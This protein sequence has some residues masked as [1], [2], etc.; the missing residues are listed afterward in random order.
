MNILL[1][2]IFIIKKSLVFSIAMVK[3]DQ[4]KWKLKMENNVDLVKNPSLKLS[5]FELLNLKEKE[6]IAEDLIYLKYNAGET[7]RKQGAFLSHVIIIVE[8]LAK[9]VLENKRDNIIVRML[10]SGSI[11]GGP[12]MFY[13]QKHHYSVIPLVSTTVVFIEKTRFRKIFNENHA[14]RDSFIS[15]MSRTMLVSFDR[16]LNLSQ[17]HIANRIAYSLFYLCDEVFG[18][19]QIAG[20]ITKLEIAELSATSVESV[21]R[22]IRK[23]EQAGYIKKEKAIIRILDKAGLK[24]YR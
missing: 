6:F 16:M 17:K 13:D 1:I 4:E 22:T 7:I 23:F 14:F 9:L 10:K 24:Q 8:G 21:S 12:G 19:N 18:T 20:E 15:E 3:F 5:I 11:I 2:M